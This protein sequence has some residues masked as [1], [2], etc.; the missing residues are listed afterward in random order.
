MPGAPSIRLYEVIFTEGTD[1]LGTIRPATDVNTDLED[2]TLFMPNVVLDIVN[3]PNPANLQVEIQLWKGSKDT[4]KRYY[5][6]GMDPASA[7]RIAIGPLNTSSGRYQFRC[8]V[9][10]FGSLSSAAET[11]GFAVKWDEDP[12]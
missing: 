10:S 9:L 4:G 8:K 12:E 5:S 7:G 6:T 2:L 1:A 11:Y 3:T